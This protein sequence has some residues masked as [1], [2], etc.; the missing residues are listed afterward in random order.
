MTF[1]RGWACF[2]W[3]TMHFGIYYQFIGKREGQLS[4]FATSGDIFGR[5]WGDLWRFATSGDEL[6]RVGTD[7][8][9][10]GE[11]VYERRDMLWYLRKWVCG[12]FLVIGG[13]AEWLE[14]SKRSLETI[15]GH[16]TM[17]LEPNRTS[18]RS[19]EWNSGDRRR[20][21]AVCRRFA[22]IGVEFVA[23][24]EWKMRHS[25]MSQFKLGVILRWGRDILWWFASIRLDFGTIRDD[26]EHCVVFGGEAEWLEMNRRSLETILGH[27]ALNWWPSKATESSL[28]KFWM[29]FWWL[30]ASRSDSEAIRI[31]SGWMCGEERRFWTIWDSLTVVSGDSSEVWNDLGKVETFYDVSGEWIFD[32][33]RRFVEV[34]ASSGP[35]MLILR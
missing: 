7:S 3:N 14:T 5:D 26:W 6:W 19:F 23:T 35:V 21:G 12:A 13:E 16:V 33:L 24:G 32:I 25:L 18:R 8:K 31:D 9:Q 11:V 34:A 28:L 1:R 2:N 27:V 30:E 20:L 17:N 4:I 10:W 29:K 15:S 22:M